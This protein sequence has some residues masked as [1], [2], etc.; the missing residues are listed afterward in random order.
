MEDGSIPSRDHD[1]AAS[2]LQHRRHQVRYEGG[3][4]VMV[5][6]YAEAVLLAAQPQHRGHKVPGRPAVG[7]DC[8][9]SASAKDVVLLPRGSMALAG[10]LAEAVDSQWTRL[11]V[12]LIGQLTIWLDVFDPVMFTAVKR[13]SARAKGGWCEF[14]ERRGVGSRTA[15]MSACRAAEDDLP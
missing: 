15:S 11:V 14:G 8:V 2:E 12:L 3:R 13:S 9:Q 10:Q 1:A 5:V 4:A 7:G 6:H